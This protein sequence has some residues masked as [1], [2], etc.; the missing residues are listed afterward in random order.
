[1][2]DPA[3]HKVGIVFGIGRVVEFDWSSFQDSVHIRTLFHAAVKRHMIYSSWAANGEGID[4]HLF[5][6]NKSL[7]EGE[8]Y[9]ETR[10]IRA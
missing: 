4:Q 9:T 5:G 6:L 10:R 7:K 3:A 1:M 8:N 2:L